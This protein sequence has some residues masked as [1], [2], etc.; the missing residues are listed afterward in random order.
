MRTDLPQQLYASSFMG[1]TGSD[2]GEHVNA[3]A[4]TREGQAYSKD[5]DHLQDTGS[6]DLLQVPSDPGMLEMVHEGALK[7]MPFVTV[8]NLQNVQMQNVGSLHNEASAVKKETVSETK[9]KNTCISA[10]KGS[11]CS[12]KIS[13]VSSTNESVENVNSGNC[14][15]KEEFQ[16]QKHLL[17]MISE[18]ATAP[19]R[20]SEVLIA[21]FKQVLSSG[22]SS[23][24]ND[25]ASLGN[26]QK[27]DP[28]SEGDVRSIV[29]SICEGQNEDELSKVSEKSAGYTK[30]ETK[31]C[32]NHFS[33][34]DLVWAKVK[35]HPWWPGQ[36]FDVAD[37]SEPAKRIHR[38]HRRLVA[39]FGDG[40][41]GWLQESQ[42][43]PFMPNFADKVRQTTVKRFCKAV[44][45]AL[46]EVCRRTELGLRCAHSSEPIYS[47]NSFPDSNVGIRK[48]VR[49]RYH[50]DIEQSRGKF[51][52][53]KVLK[54]IQTA[55]SSPLYPL[56]SG[57]EYAELC[58]HVYG[59]RSYLLSPNMPESKI[60]LLNMFNAHK[61]ALKALQG[62]AVKRRL[63]LEKPDG[64]AKTTAVKEA[65][66]PHQCKD[67]A[68]RSLAGFRVQSPKFESKDR[69]LLKDLGDF[70]SHKTE[71]KVKEKVK[72][73]SP[74]ERGH[75]EGNVL[76]TVEPLQGPTELDANPAV[77]L[78]VSEDDDS[79][80]LFDITGLYSLK[81]KKECTIRRPRNL[82]IEK[83]DKRLLKVKQELADK[84]GAFELYETMEDEMC[85]RESGISSSST[86]VH[87]PNPCSWLK[88]VS[89]VENNT[90]CHPDIRDSNVMEYMQVKEELV[91]SSIPCSK[92][93]GKLGKKFY[94][95]ELG[96]VEIHK[97]ESFSNLVTRENCGRDQ[98]KLHDAVTREGSEGD[99]E[100][101]SSKTT[102]KAKKRPSQNS[103]GLQFLSAAVNNKTKKEM[104]RLHSEIGSAE[105]LLEK[106]TA[107][108]QNVQDM[109][110]PLLCPSMKSGPGKLKKDFKPDSGLKISSDPVKGIPPIT[111]SVKHI[112]SNKDSSAIKSEEGL[113]IERIH[114]PQIS[115]TRSRD[116]EG[117][118]CFLAVLLGTL[119]LVAVDPTSGANLRSSS[120]AATSVF[121]RFRNMV[122]VKSSGYAA[123]A[124]VKNIPSIAHGCTDGDKKV[125]NK[126]H[127][128]GKTVFHKTGQIHLEK[129][130]LE[131]ISLSK[132]ETPLGTLVG[133]QNKKLTDTSDEGRVVLM[134]DNE[135]MLG[136]H[137]P[138]IQKSSSVKDLK[139]S[140]LE[141]GSSA[142]AETP[143]KEHESKELVF[144]NSDGAKALAKEG[145]VALGGQLRCLQ[146]TFSFDDTDSGK[147]AG[148]MKASHTGKHSVCLQE[149]TTAARK[150]K[151]EV[152]QESAVSKM[153]GKG[154]AVRKLPRVWSLGKQFHEKKLASTRVYAN[155]VK[156][157]I[158]KVQNLLLPKKCSEMSKRKTEVALGLMIQFPEDYLLPSEVELKE[159]F[160]RFG[161]IIGMKVYQNTLK[162]QVVFK[163]KAVAEGAWQYASRNKL[164]GQADVTYKLRYFA[165]SSKNNS[166]HVTPSA[167]VGP[168][169][170]RDLKCS[171]LESR[172]GTCAGTNPA[173]DPGRVSKQAPEL[174]GVSNCEL[175]PAYCS[176]KGSTISE[177]GPVSAMNTLIPG[178]LETPA[179]AFINLAT[180]KSDLS[181]SSRYSDYQESIQSPSQSGSIA[182]ILTPPESDINASS[183]D[184]EDQ[185]LKLLQQVSVIVSSTSLTPRSI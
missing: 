150:R 143:E 163:H 105:R 94:H 15:Q 69:V 46:E 37:A 64:S 126:R 84:G 173:L 139:A 41:F 56:S 47:S 1:K 29:E 24:G 8:E 16:K 57:L 167:K 124:S 39:F 131:Q 135:T 106:P 17:N 108:K 73:G 72:E 121:L 184:I 30:E 151:S 6:S 166:K 9:V 49:L 93:T 175:L 170:T 122:F 44:I 130:S 133:P 128:D 28:P 50:Q 112:E 149:L 35:S 26:Q 180:G 120:K 48:G 61:Q 74:L 38:P 71:R 129:Y 138:E 62:S 32:V 103:N 86:T 98:E 78:L 117:S 45:G 23:D 21:T 162:A 58:G 40:T 14:G 81:K 65:M 157:Q 144:N 89:N 134:K 137:V 165:Q 53:L 33:V 90:K 52:P 147:A 174:E 113:A 2:C 87:E 110:S 19:K 141:H 34:G 88:D 154:E 118:T 63:G 22:T 12:S 169:E 160:G 181:G 116:S 183:G 66:R 5:I 100:V 114:L 95:P 158:T 70:K 4:C 172:E 10:D 54:F 51:Q 92:G 127:V 101:E 155:N 91:Q 182:S 176:A 119:K 145:H 80:T 13:M 109:G 102:V 82:L 140:L 76:S 179:C 60:T 152:L 136:N 142:E 3:G 27:L 115:I 164:F 125:D 25:D 161:T 11:H 132:S 79:K 97:G 96:G 43:I 153:L 146:N 111:K 178:L 177:A 159:L 104:K 55:A 107:K 75:E 85:P 36:V 59:F 31:E 168:P 148:F 20:E 18:L 123:A 7:V 83:V 171:S 68:H 185:M 77:D 42:L 67:G 99:L 156:G